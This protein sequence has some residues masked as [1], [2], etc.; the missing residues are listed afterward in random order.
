MRILIG[1]DDTDNKES[2]GTGYNSRM[3]ASKLVEELHIN[4][5]G[6]T[7]HQLF[8][9]RRVPYTSQNSSACLIVENFDI[10]KIHQ[11]CRD[12]LLSTAVDGSD[13]GLCIIKEKQITEEI[14]NWGFRAKREILTQDE[15]R[16]IA[17]RA[18][19]I[20]EGLTGDFQGIIGSMAA[21]GL[22]HHGMD[23]RFIQIKPGFHLREL[24]QGVMSCKELKE[25]SGADKVCDSY[26]REIKDKEIIFAGEWIRPVLFSKKSNI[27]AEKTEHHEYQW[28]TASKE[29]IKSLSN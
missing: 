26:F 21:C 25:I 16:A 15:A 7:R 2:R 3:M 1:I 10:D 6:I 28:E 14:I 29:C 8:F 27:I 22:R 17:K 23:G 11:V 5:Y 12:Y 13:V 19:I 18:G 9:D 4:V 20:L 24:Q